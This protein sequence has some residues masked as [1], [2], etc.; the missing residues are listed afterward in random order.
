MK[1]FVELDD[2]LFFADFLSGKDSI[3][4]TD[5]P[6]KM[7]QLEVWFDPE[8]LLDLDNLYLHLLRRCPLD[9]RGKLTRQYFRQ[10]LI[11]SSVNEYINAPEISYLNAFW[12]KL[13]KFLSDDKKD[14]E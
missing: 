11:F 3:D 13:T 4:T 2:E 14:L 9:L 10:L 1:R 6:E 8:F 7:K 12:T 5:I